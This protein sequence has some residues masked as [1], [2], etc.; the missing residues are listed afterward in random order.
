M[1]TQKMGK[2][3]LTRHHESEWNKIGKWTGVTDVHLSPLGFE[4]A[5][6]MGSLVTDIKFDYIFTSTMIR[7]KE[8]LA[9][10]EEG[11]TSHYQGAPV[12]ES[13][14]INERDYG[15]YT[16]KNKWEIEKEV[17]EDQFIKIRR[18]WDYQIPNGESLKMVYERSVPFFL[19]RIL[20]ILRE[21]KNILV[22]CHGNSSRAMIKYIEGISD[23]DISKIEM[24][25]GDVLVYDLDQDGHIVHKE[26][27]HTS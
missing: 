23:D 4:K 24:P 10:M 11:Y 17:G 12:E 22:V 19:N 8:T 5:K 14:D 7:A 3:V 13:K 15:D 20:P 18:S 9:C 25:F 21:G 2:F 16:G 6:Q 1:E 27:R 26:V